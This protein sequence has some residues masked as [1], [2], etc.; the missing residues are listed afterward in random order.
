MRAVYIGI[1]IIPLLKLITMSPVNLWLKEMDS[2]GDTTING[3][4]QPS[5]PPWARMGNTPGKHN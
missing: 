5:V 1:F 2:D 3:V 4:K